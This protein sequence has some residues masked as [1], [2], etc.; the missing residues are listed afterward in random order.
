MLELRS[1]LKRAIF[2]NSAQRQV[3]PISR[4]LWLNDLN[5]FLTYLS[6]AR[7]DDEPVS[8]EGDD[9][10]REGGEEDGDGQ[11][12]PDHQFYNL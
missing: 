7:C 1:F 6:F 9:G 5:L 8:V 11:R 12:G 2:F 3:C 4:G 10:D